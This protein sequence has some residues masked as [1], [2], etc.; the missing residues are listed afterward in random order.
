MTLKPASDA[1]PDAEVQVDTLVEA[2]R[3]PRTARGERTRNKILEAA[4]Q[5]FAELGYTEASIVRITDAAG[6][7]QG[8]FYL[9][10]ES[11]LEVFERLVEDL[12]R[13]VRHAMADRAQQ[14]TTRLERERLGFQGFFEF[15]AQHPALYRIIREA[16]FVSPRSLRLHYSRIVEGYTKGLVDAKAEGEITADPEVAAWILMGI[17]EM[18]GMRW[19]LWGDTPQDPNAPMGGKTQ[20]VPDDVFNSMMKFIQ[21][22]LG[23]HVPSE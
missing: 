22:G 5:V 20:Q 3:K 7:G 12:N 4:E 18:V 14:G 10:F 16:E 23:A 15:T 11:K 2:D 6:V 13:R 21:A 9:Y 8:T 17:G 19:V 1:G